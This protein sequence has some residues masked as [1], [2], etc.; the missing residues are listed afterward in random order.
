MKGFF[1]RLAAWI[2]LVAV[3]AATVALLIMSAIQAANKP[4]DA[5]DKHS[6]IPLN[7]TNPVPPCDRPPLNYSRPLRVEVPE[8]DGTNTSLYCGWPVVNEAVRLPTASLS[9]LVAAFII[10]LGMWKAK[11]WAVWIGMLLSG[12]LAFGFFVAMCFD[13]NSV[14]IASEWCATE[15][16]TKGWTCWYAE[17]VSLVL[18]DAGLALAY[19]ILTLVLYA[20]ARYFMK[21]ALTVVVEHDHH[22]HVHAHA[23]DEVSASL[24]QNAAAPPAA[25]SNDAGLITTHRDNGG[26]SYEAMLHRQ[27][28]RARQQ[29]EQERDEYTAL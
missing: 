20:T 9:V 10:V 23:S 15:A 25:P 11:R 6:L 13:A 21:D 17:Y 4:V 18:L 8:K 26:E 12:V 16:E 7:G 19:F 3:A 14:R 5:D 29:T 2:L 27:F 24:M 28:E 1:V 22:V